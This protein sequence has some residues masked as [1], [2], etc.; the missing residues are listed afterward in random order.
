MEEQNNRLIASFPN[1]VFDRSFFSNK[2]FIEIIGNFIKTVN[3]LDLSSKREEEFNLET[4]VVMKSLG[5]LE[6]EDELEDV[7]KVLGIVL[8][9]K[10]IIAVNLLTT[11]EKLLENAE[12]LKYSK[13]NRKI[14]INFEKENTKP[15]LVDLFCGS[16][17][18]SL[19]FIQSGFKV[20]FA[21]DIEQSALRTYSFNHPEIDGRSI[22]KGGI[23]GFAHNVH[24]Y[25]NEPVDV[26]A[27]GPPC[28]GFSTANRQRVIDDPRNILYKYYVEAVKNITPK[29]FVMENVKGM[30]N[31]A[32]QIKEDFNLNTL[33]G[34]DIEFEVFNARKFGIPQNRDRL[35]F[36]GV[37]S[38]IAE[39]YSITAL[40]IIN[41][42]KNDFTED[43]LGLLEAIATLPKLEA[44]KVK[45]DTS[46]ESKESGGKIMKF[47]SEKSNEYINSINMGRQQDLLFNHKAR[48][49][50]ERDI[51]IFSRMLPG[52]KSDSPR[53]SDIMPYKSRSHM[54][55]DKYYKLLPD[56]PCKTITAHMKFDCNMYI[57]PFQARGLTP[58]EAARVQSYPDDYFILGPYTKTYQQIGNSVPPIMARKI[59]AKIIKYL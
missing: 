11:N 47:K 2:E 18:L 10:L 38:D 24:K 15:T 39:K 51:E 6:N 21:N 8:Y 23:E 54:F 59:S 28:Q 53:I 41:E 27:G 20:V 26:L 33:V 34:Y 4:I 58:R 48:Y 57:H 3:L 14:L 31:V 22:T 55:K 56:S 29:F 7:E 19:G 25:I 5:I 44:S 43:E 17:G 52:D 30:R 40:D 50:N 1:N 13:E 12:I 36:I 16:G 35:I 49:N 46:N 32:Q 37:R 45:N 42:I 9:K